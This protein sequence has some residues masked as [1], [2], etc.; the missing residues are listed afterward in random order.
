MGQSLKGIS[1]SDL[2][3][4]TGFQARPPY[5]ETESEYVAISWV[6]ASKVSGPTGFQAR[7]PSLGSLINLPFCSHMQGWPISPGSHAMGA[8]FR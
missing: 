7:R 5:I 1:N 6:R 2:R 3:G 8:R 4:S